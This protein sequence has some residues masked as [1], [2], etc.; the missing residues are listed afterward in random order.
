M[1]ALLAV[2]AALLTFGPAEAGGLAAGP[3][4]APNKTTAA[5]A[6]AV[7]IDDGRDP[8]DDDDPDDGAADAEAHPRP[9]P[10]VRLGMLPPAGSA[11]RHLRRHARP[12]NERGPPALL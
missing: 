7:T 2:F 8:L 6:P 3:A 1:S 11:P 5:F 9:V 4:W 10:P 12:E